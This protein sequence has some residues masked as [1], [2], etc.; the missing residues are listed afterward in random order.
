M[1]VKIAELAPYIGLCLSVLVLSVLAT[2]LIVNLAKKIG[3][4]ATPDGRTL[5]KGAKPLGGG[6][7][8][9]VLALGAWVLWAWPLSPVYIALLVSAIILGVVSLIDDFLTVSAALRFSLQMIAVAICLYFLPSEQHVIWTGWSIVIDRL[10]TG[11]CWLWFINLYNFMDGID[12]LAASE[13]ISICIGVV[14]IGYFVGLP[15]DLVLLA[16]LVA[17][18]AAGFLPWNW[19]KSR[20]MLGDLGSIP[21]GFLLGFLLINLAMKGYLVAALL[22]PLY[23]VADASITLVRR[24]LTGERFWQ[25]HN[26]HFYQNA[27][28]WGGLGHD[29][30]VIR[31]IGA[32]IIFIGAAFLSLSNSMLAVLLAGFTL[33]LLLW[34]FLNVA[35][36]SQLAFKDA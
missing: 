32:N 15:I 17:C 19:H 20:I 36:R 35:R 24:I 4:V 18:G 7:P 30:V 2:G 5:H 25:P 14:L 11:L 33:A 27:T 29:Q 12:G 13:T 28:K 3:L 9:I 23:F 21:I 8:V 22:L 10:V 34:H 16:A 31:I 1:P 26:T 6:G